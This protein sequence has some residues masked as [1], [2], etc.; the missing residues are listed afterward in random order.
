MDNLYKKDVRFLIGV[1]AFI[2]MAVI[3]I[4]IMDI[5]IV[6]RRISR[7]LAKMIRCTRNFKYGDDN[8]RLANVSSM[9][10]LGIE[11][12][13]EIGE[14]YNMFVLSLKES[15]Y[16]MTNFKQ[17]K[18]DILDKEEKLGEM[19]KAA[20]SDAL[21]GVGNKTS[22]DEK[23]N[24]LNEVIA[25]KKACF[26]VVMADLNNLKYINDTFGHKSGDEYIV[27]CCNILTDVYKH[28]PVFRV[29]GDEFV[30]IIE[31]QDYD[32]REWLFEKTKKR[33]ADSYG[34]MDKE[35]GFPNCPCN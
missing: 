27:G 5:A 28:S 19:S 30:I 13:D 22:F 31:N 1:I 16:Y 8:D 9:E 3:L 35:S 20:M 7:P 18:N 11:S 24:E 34:K 33:F 25:G 26:A 32:S 2:L 10:K 15:R 21:T 23:C 6:R 17:A 14:L 4:L 12:M 29:G